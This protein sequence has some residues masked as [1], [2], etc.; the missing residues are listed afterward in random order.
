MV[1]KITGLRQWIISITAIIII[2]IGTVILV[3]FAQ[4]YNYDAFHNKIYKTGLVLIDSTPN[5]AEIFLNDRGINKKTPY[6]Y[7]SA[8]EGNLE[9]DLQKDQYRNWSKKTT[10]VPGEVTFVNYA[11][12]LPNTLDQKPVG[13]NILFNRIIQ[14][15]NNQK[16]YALAKSPLSIYSI[17]DDANIREI[18]SASQSS[19]PANPIVDLYNIKVSNDGQRLLF[20][21]KLTNNVV[22]TVSIDVPS[23]KISNLTTEF[24]FVFN[25]IRFNPKNSSELFWLDAGV[26]KKIQINEK[27]ISSNIIDSIFQLDIEEDRLLVFKTSTVAGQ[28]VSLYSY[29][30]SGGNE[31]LLRQL[32]FDPKGYGILFVR[33]RY[34]EYLSVIYNSSSLAELVKN[35]YQK[36]DLNTQIKTI[37]A[38]VSQQ[39]ISPSNRFLIYNQNS[40]LRFI[41]LEFGQDDN[42]GAS[43]VDLQEWA[44]YDDYHLIV[45]QNDTLRILDYDG[46]NNYLLTPINDITGFGIQLN[47]K[48]ILPLNSSGN[49]YKLYLT[50]K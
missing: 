19:D 35:P 34:A 46:Q 33:S 47:Q 42:Y 36:S 4:G 44:W 49:L 48:S 20:D 7:T 26:L 2:T 3:A 38:G 12:L 18:Y 31:N 40:T 13:S 17:S 25:D 37:G 22:Q 10:V 41:D 39:T 9:V 15:E 21:Q 6:R 1:K 16:T 24:G 50:K 30:L 43:L 45:R 23:L 11:L 14:S 27:N 32:E 8:P 5:N 28:P 29:D